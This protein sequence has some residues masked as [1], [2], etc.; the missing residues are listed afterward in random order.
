MKRTPLQLVIKLSFFCMDVCCSESKQQ[1]ELTPD[2]ICESGA[3][4]RRK[5]LQQNW[6]GS[7]SLNFGRIYAHVSANFPDRAH[8]RGNDLQSQ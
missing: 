1:R 5:V 7:S 8:P 6:A 2:D 3:L 4:R